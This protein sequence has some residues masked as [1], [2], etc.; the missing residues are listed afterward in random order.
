LTLNCVQFI[1][2][3]NLFII[4]NTLYLFEYYLNQLLV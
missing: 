2:N 4:N 3:N 1:S